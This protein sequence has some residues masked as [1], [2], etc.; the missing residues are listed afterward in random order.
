M[1][2]CLS[3]F[4][5]V[6]RIDKVQAEMKHWFERWYSSI[7]QLHMSA[8]CWRI[9]YIRIDE[10]QVLYIFGFRIYRFIYLNFMPRLLT[11]LSRSRMKFS[12]VI[13]TIHLQNIFES[14]RHLR[15]SHPFWF[16]NVRL[17][18]LILDIWKLEIFT[19]VF[20]TK[21]FLHSV[22]SSHFVSWSVSTIECTIS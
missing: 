1:C 3:N 16:K 15:K 13:L 7:P 9:S 17:E 14:M 21:W 4:R 10:T 8:R 12:M 5:A 2:S 22:A 6:W 11:E 20:R 18:F 19:K